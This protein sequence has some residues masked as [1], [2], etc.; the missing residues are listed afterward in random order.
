MKV[1]YRISWKTQC[2]WNNCKRSGKPRRNTCCYTCCYTVSLEKQNVL[3]KIS[4][5]LATL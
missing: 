1:V 3:E 2:P 5:D 4:S